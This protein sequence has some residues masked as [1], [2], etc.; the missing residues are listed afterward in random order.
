MCLNNTDEPYR[1][2]SWLQAM[3]QKIVPSCV[4][5]LFAKLEAAVMPLLLYSFNHP[6]TYI[7][8]CGFVF[9]TA[10]HVSTRMAILDID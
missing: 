5:R 9:M 7:S 2:C 1:D 6:C 3:L 10:V 8:A 4:R